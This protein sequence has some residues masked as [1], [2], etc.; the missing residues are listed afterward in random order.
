MARLLRQRLA[1]AAPMALTASLAQ[2]QFVAGEPLPAC[3]E[4]AP[5]TFAPPTP[6]LETPAATSPRAMRL[7]ATLAEIRTQQTD[8]AYSHTTRIVP[9]RGIFH[10]D[11]SAMM[12]WL[13]QRVAPRVVPATG[14]RMVA[15]DVASL[16]EHQRGFSSIARFVDAQPGDVFAWRRPAGFP[17]T[18][19][20]HCGV[21]LSRPALVRGYPQLAAVRIAD[22]TSFGHQNDTR[23]AGVSGVGEGTIV[24]ALDENG[25][26][27]AYGWAG[28]L[29]GGYVVTP[30]LLGRLR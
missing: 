25:A 3:I 6:A 21:I 9:R 1:W 11:C 19:T 26:G 27:R 22:S 8:G 15:R 16:I 12:Q 10:W 4:H 13:L 30:I 5:Y 24:F 23:A 29:S 14:H 18:N 17:S 2:A 7:L 20:G 28:T